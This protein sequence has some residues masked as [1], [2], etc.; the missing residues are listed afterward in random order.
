MSNV[1]SFLQK[2]VNQFPEKPAIGFKKDHE[3]KEL[4]WY[5]LKRIVYKTAN[6]LKENGVKEN[7]KVS[8]YADNSAEWIIFDLAI[9]AIGAVT[10]PVYSTNGEDQ[11]EYI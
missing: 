10:V 4:S 3:W 2:N 6:A 11:V 8:I 1:T 7:D 5:K 9:M